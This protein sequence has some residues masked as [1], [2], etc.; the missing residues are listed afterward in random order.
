MTFKLKYRKFKLSM[1]ALVVWGV[2]T[3]GFLYGTAPSNTA[4]AEDA[5]PALT[6]VETV[7]AE[8]SALRQWRDFSGRL[9]AVDAAQIR[10]LV[11]GAVQRV[12]FEDG[13]QVE[14]GQI[15][16]V[17][18]P[19]PFEARVQH[20]RASLTSAESDLALAQVEFDR[21]D[22]LA[23][24]Q[25]VSK[26]I[27]DTRENALHIAKAVRESVRAQLAQ[28]ELDLEYAY[29]KAPISGR[30]GRAEVTVGNV[31]QAGPNAPLL[32]T[33]VNLERLYA[34]FDV[35]EDTYFRIM[36]G[37][38][39]GHSDGERSVSGGVP[40]EVAVG[41]GRQVMHRASLHAFD[42][43]LDEHTGTIR[44]RAIVENVDRT[45]IPGV[46]INVRIGTVDTKPTLLVPERA[47]SVSQSKRFVYVVNTSDIV[48][49][50]EVTLGESLESQRVILSGIE[51]GD[52][53]IVNGIQR[54]MSDMQVAV[55]QI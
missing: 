12:L 24:N 31:V 35:D 38:R 47:I 50:R 18:D 5:V 14:Q 36:R 40:V 10:P 37:V 33:V 23:G 32:T 52:R 15:L 44:A 6:A 51:R 21:A 25:A 29:V 17:I 27:R 39:S 26:S 19:R 49:Y 8:F 55:T 43:Q 45:L 9:Q 20:A 11:S 53:V 13:A 4:S 28:A 16:F 3:A 30:V 34:E 54:V 46:F 22:A 2:A 41:S 7:T 42:N 48:E 1:M